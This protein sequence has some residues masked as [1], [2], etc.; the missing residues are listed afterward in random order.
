MP[1][2][3]ILSLEDNKSCWHKSEAHTRHTASLLLFIGRLR[4]SKNRQGDQDF[5]VKMG[6][7]V[8]IEGL[9]IEGG[10]HCFSLVMNRF[11]RNNALF[12]A[13]LSV[14][15]IFFLNPLIPGI[16]ISNH[17]L[18]LNGLKSCCSGP[19]W[20]RITEAELGI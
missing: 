2:K 9:P 7:V 3:S 17:I 10:K 11:C 15:F 20:S 18:D 1:L 14:I 12:S 5:L 8:H 16:I 4:F 19:E 6:R 13:S